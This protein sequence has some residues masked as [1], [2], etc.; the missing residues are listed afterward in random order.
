MPSPRIIAHALCVLLALSGGSAMSATKLTFTH[1]VVDANPPSGSGCCLD[2]CALGDLDGDGRTDIVVGSQESIGL[3]WYHN[4]DWKRSV[5]SPGEFTTDGVV[6]DI[7]GDGKAGV[8]ASCID[9]DQIEWYERT[10]DPFRPEGWRRH[11]IGGGWAH[12]LA[13]GDING[14]GRLDVVAFSKYVNPPHLV[15]YEAPADPRQEWIRHEF[16]QPA[17]EGLDVGDL[18]GDGHLDTAAGRYWYRNVDGRGG[19]WEKRQVT[20]DWTDDCRVVIADMNGDG[21]LDIVLGPSEGKGHLSWFENP[22]WREHIIDAETLEGAHSLGVAD[23]DGDGRPEVMAGEMHTSPGKRV[24]VYRRGAEG[25]QWQRLVL[26]TT[27]THNA[28]V[29]RL[30][31]GALPAIVGK[32]YEGPKQVEIWQAVLVPAT[33]ESK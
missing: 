12:D 31:P 11:R 26:A 29:G 7:N 3:V 15:W 30:S 13:V 5:I 22:T 28:Q 25:E 1:Q 2:V 20:T 27:G 9:R 24:L 19:K 21:K 10:G 18:D 32:N 23:F 16:D 17:G 8:I 6:A 4:P 33:G 14:D